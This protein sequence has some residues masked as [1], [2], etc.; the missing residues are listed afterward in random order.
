MAPIISNLYKNKI[1]EA[2]H[3]DQRSIF[4]AAKIFAKTEGITPA[5]ESAHAIKKAIDEAIKAKEEKKEKNI[6]FLL[7][8]HGFLDLS[9]YEKNREI[10]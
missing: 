2:C 8:G 9:A 10:S 6:V 3:Y 7:S 1:I 5:P 4:E